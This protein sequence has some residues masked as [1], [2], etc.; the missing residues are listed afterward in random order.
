MI[1]SH[2]A[3]SYTAL[4]EPASRFEPCNGQFGSGSINMPAG[5][6]DGFLYVKGRR[7]AMMKVAGNRVYPKE[8]V[9]QILVGG[10]VQEAEVGGFAAG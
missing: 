7:D 6:L 3:A 2:G 4:V 9:D 10:H 1:G 8:I 5:S